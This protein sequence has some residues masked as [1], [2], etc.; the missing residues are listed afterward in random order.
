MNIKHWLHRARKIISRLAEND[1]F[2]YTIPMRAL[3]VFSALAGYAALSI[4]TSGM[5]VSALAGEGSEEVIEKVRKELDPVAFLVHD[6][7]RIRLMGTT[8]D[9]ARLEPLPLYESSPSASDWQAFCEARVAG[10]HER[11]DDIAA[12]I[13][14]D[15]RGLCVANAEPASLPIL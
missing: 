7:E 15:L 12:M 3:F 10:S 1:T 13:L 11:C 2:W 8:E 9:C 4:L 5:T 14:P 6:I